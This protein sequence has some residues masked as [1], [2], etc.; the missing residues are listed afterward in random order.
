MEAN[1]LDEDPVM[2]GLVEMPPGWLSG[3]CPSLADPKSLKEEPFCCCVIEGCGEN[4]GGGKV[5]AKAPLGGTGWGK[6]GPALL[7]PKLGPVAKPLGW[8]GLV[9]GSWG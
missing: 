3:L 8:N 6:P 7:I 9:E 2:K 5:L 4:S 1:G